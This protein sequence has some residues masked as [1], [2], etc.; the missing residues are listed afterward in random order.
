MLQRGLLF[1][2]DFTFL[3]N[4][5]YMYY[6]IV[7]VNNLHVNLSYFQD[8]HANISVMRSNIYLSCLGYHGLAGSEIYTIQTW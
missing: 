8:T 4:G 3:I 1:F 6:L 2:Y 7:H 5:M